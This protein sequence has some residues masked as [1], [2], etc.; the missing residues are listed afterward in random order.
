MSSPSPRS[1]D[2]L[3]LGL[4]PYREVW[5]LQ[6]KLQAALIAGDGTDTVIACQ[7]PAVITR[8][9]STAAGSL[10]THKAELEHQGIEV[11]DIERGGDITFHG[12]GQLVVYPILN[13][14]HYRTDVGWYMRQLEE[15]VLCTLR[16][17][18]IE[19]M[20]VPGRT[21]V[22]I[23]PTEKI[24]SIGVRISRWCT[25]HGLALNIELQ[26]ETGFEAMTPCGIADIAMTSMERVSGQ[27]TPVTVVLEGIRRSFQEVF[28]IN[29]LSIEYSP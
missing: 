28:E 11:I 21:G 24:A 10:L 5:D 6:R 2:W 12:P 22:W 7:H 1:V 13:L 18:S 29:Q 16:S 14:R 23:S 26:S 3:D 27:P 25:M 9:R 4:R 15:V 20:R 19:G 8:G 17:S